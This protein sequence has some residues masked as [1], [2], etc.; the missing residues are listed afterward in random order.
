MSTP[1]VKVTNLHKVYGE[2]VAVDDVSF[3]VEAG[4]IFGVL[5]PNGAGKTTA[6][7]CVAGLRHADGGHLT[8][9]GVDPQAEP[10]RVRPFLGIQFQEAGLHDKITVEEALHLFAGFYPK[11]ADADALIRLLDLEDKRTTQYVKLS[12]GQK[13]R[14]SIALALVGSPKVAILDELTQGLDPAARRATWDL[15]RKV[16]DAGVTVI[17]VTHFMEEAER[18]CDRLVIIDAGRVVAQGSPAELIASVEGATSLEDVFV[19]LTGH[20]SEPTAHD[21]ATVLNGAR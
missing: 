17:L 5:G 10:E 7:E 13:Q 1:V 15:V 14:L 20:S 18:L 2:K 16:R 19:A 11:P 8:V 4:E 6:V 21:L 12:G 9:L 3:T